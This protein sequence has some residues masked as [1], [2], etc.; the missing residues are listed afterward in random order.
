MEQLA[1]SFDQISK[2]VNVILSVSTRQRHESL[3]VAKHA[4]LLRKENLSL[5]DENGALHNTIKSHKRSWQQSEQ[6]CQSLAINLKLARAQLVTEEQKRREVDSRRRD[7]EMKCKTLESQIHNISRILMSDKHSRSLLSF[8]NVEGLELLQRPPTSD[9][10]A[11]CESMDAADQSIDPN[12]SDLSQTGDFDGSHL[13]SGRKWRRSI[14][15][16]TYHDDGESD[17]GVL[18]PPRKKRVSLSLKDKLPATSTPTVHIH[19]GASTNVSEFSPPKTDHV[20]SPTQRHRAATQA[21]KRPPTRKF[22]TGSVDDVVNGGG[23]ENYPPAHGATKATAN[24]TSVSM[25][26]N[27]AAKFSSRL[28]CSGKPRV[29]GGGPR[30]NGIQS[31]I[32]DSPSKRGIVRRSGS[33]DSTKG[34]LGGGPG[35]FPTYTSSSGDDDKASAAE[36]H[37]APTPYHELFPEDADAAEIRPDTAKSSLKRQASS[38]SIQTLVESRPHEFVK[39]HKF[40]K[41][42]C[43]GCQQTIKLASSVMKCKDC[44][45]VCHENCRDRCPL[46]CIPVSQTPQS[47]QA[48][49]D[50]S[51]ESFVPRR[52]PYVPSLVIHCV[53]EVEKRG[54]DIVG[55]YRLPGSDKRYKEL[56]AKLLKGSKASAS[57]LM[58][59]DIHNVTSTLKLFFRDLRDPLIPSAYFGS[60]FEAT[61]VEPSTERQYMMKFA[62][63]SLPVANRHTLAYLVLHLLRV[64]QQSVVNKMACNN[65]ATVFAP[66]LL[67][68][69]GEQTIGTMVADVA[70]QMAILMVIFSIS[71]DFWSELIESEDN[72]GGSPVACPS[73]VAF[74]HQRSAGSPLSSPA[75]SPTGSHQSNKFHHQ[76]RTPVHL[77]STT[78]AGSPVTPEGKQA[79]DIASVLGPITS[80]AQQKNRGSSAAPTPRRALRKRQGGFFSNVKG[81]AV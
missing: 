76:L 39:C 20:L 52:A 43:K 11:A 23:D 21:G 59:E 65:L 69:P 1:P 58:T 66:T 78:S 18:S 7:V 48:A 26:R 13:R 28:G 25:L 44:R 67:A 75:G 55:I 46:P 36:Y 32:P 81:S 73:P 24:A 63:R 79:P 40:T 71:T 56:K 19:N 57:L 4:E 62:V 8:H 15:Q 80:S 37:H 70:K 54:L 49:K 72:N 47:K 22:R 29:L 6:E 64:A 34:W 10:E 74:A 42:S 9:D 14:L 68:S 5:Q 2:G 12:N 30:P 38:A 17:D 50:G 45:F 27:S 61:E 33:L 53:K 31:L 41:E 77:K 16:E 3:K 60:F 51:L 35:S